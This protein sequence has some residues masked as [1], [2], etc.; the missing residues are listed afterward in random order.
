[1]RLEKEIA[2]VQKEASGLSGRLNNKKFVDKAPAEVVA[3]AQAQH[4]ELQEKLERLQASLKRV[5]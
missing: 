3:Q 1:V 2:K 5:S 4:A